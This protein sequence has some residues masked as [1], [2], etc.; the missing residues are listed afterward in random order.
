MSSPLFMLLLL[1]LL[2]VREEDE[3]AGDDTLA[4]LIEALKSFDMGVEEAAVADI[5]L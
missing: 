1:F 5:S 2:S 4:P 3:S